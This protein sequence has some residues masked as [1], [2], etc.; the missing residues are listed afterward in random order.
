ML[1][2]V[3]WLL[4]TLT[5]WMT[6]LIEHHRIEVLS[7]GIYEHKHE[8]KKYEDANENN[9]KWRNSLLLRII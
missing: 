2:S 3:R 4:C 6:V 9:R 7:F 5:D 1:H 8:A